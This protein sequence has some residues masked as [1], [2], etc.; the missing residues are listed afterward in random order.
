MRYASITDE[1]AECTGVVCCTCAGDE[2]DGIIA[3]LRILPKLD[4][5]MVEDV[6]MGLQ[7]VERLGRQHHAH[8]IPAIH[9]WDHLQ[10]EVW[11]GNLHGYRWLAKH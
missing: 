7:V 3:V 4:V 8:V 10:K 6:G 5:G 1:H 2:V 11:V 9:Q